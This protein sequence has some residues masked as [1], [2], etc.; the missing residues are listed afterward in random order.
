VEAHA[1]EFLAQLI[2][3][4]R[5]PSVAAQ[6]L[7]IT[8]AAEATLALCQQV[9][10]EARLVPVGDGAPVVVAEGGAGERRLMIYDHYD[11][12]PPDPLD[13]WLSPPFE[14]EVREGVLYGR[15]VADNKGNLVARLAAIRAYQETLGPLPTQVLCVFEGEE[16]IGS[17]H[18]GQFARE[19]QELLAGVEGCL[20][21]AGY[22]DESERATVSLG[23]KGIVAVDLRVRTADVDAHSG[24]GGLLPNAAWR[25][26]EALSTLRRPDGSVSLDGLLDHVLSPSAADLALLETIPFD[27]SAFVQ[28]IGAQA[29]LGGLQGREALAR[30]FYQ[31]SLTING[32][33]SG[34]Q[35]QGTKTVIPCQASAKLDF[36]LVPNLTP[37][38]TV[39]LLQEHLVRHGFGD[40]KV[41]VAEV[42]EMPAR[43]APESPF[44]QAA[45]AALADVEPE[46]PV[47]YPLLP[48]SGPMH[49]LCQTWGIPAASFGVG[50]ADSR[51]HAPNENI[52]LEDFV[53]GIKVVGRLLHRVSQ[54]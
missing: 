19:N 33:T 43:S 22:R 34:Y 51:T 49:Q 15:G 27:A 14:P 12:Q 18:L 16:E 24:N 44:V 7:G 20:W 26:V 23:L 38:L 52:R 35:G 11:V 41:V 1:E 25:L 4:V 37:D 39:S 21:E 47:V 36:R 5:V 30:W 13:E 29:P 10:L 48:G 6:G 2:D 42:G 40:V 50:N 32:L 28:R 45:I 17:P 8:E 3:L 31:P 46:P 54:L 53:I 9:G